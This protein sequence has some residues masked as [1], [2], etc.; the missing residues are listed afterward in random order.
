MKESTEP[1]RGN[2]RIADVCVLIPVSQVGA[3]AQEPGHDRNHPGN[4][5]IFTQVTSG[6]PPRVRRFG[7][8]SQP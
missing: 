5:T 6:Q 8:P 4:L 7:F 3:L 1:R 2:S